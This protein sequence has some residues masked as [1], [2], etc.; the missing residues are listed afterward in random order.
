V[1][2][3]DLK[4]LPIIEPSNPNWVA[5]RQWAEFNLER[6]REGRENQAADIRKLDV[7]LGSI[8]FCKMLLELP[9]QIRQ[10]HKRDPV[11]NDVGFDIPDL[12]GNKHVTN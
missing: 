8:I 7:E 5:V 4:E 11:Q 10:E 12:T 9:Q 6:L 2:E 1:T 3:L